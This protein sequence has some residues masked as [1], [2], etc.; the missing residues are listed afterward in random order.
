MCL[1][2]SRRHPFGVHG[3]DL[4][5]D[6][7]DDADLVLF[8]YLWIEFA[9]PVAGNGH[10][11]ISEAGAQCLAALPVAVVVRGLAAVRLPFSIII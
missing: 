4:L 9:L 1:N 3:Q 8:Q 10:F 7:L 5:L 6:V 11:H 2:I